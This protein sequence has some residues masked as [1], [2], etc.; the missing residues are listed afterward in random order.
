MCTL[1]AD[2]PDRVEAASLVPPRQRFTPTVEGLA[3]AVR[4]LTAGPLPA[5]DRVLDER[6]RAG[7]LAFDALFIDTWRRLTAPHAGGRADSRRPELSP[8]SLH[9]A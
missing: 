2:A 4:R 3:A 6:A 5:G 7:S 8:R 1:V 9:P